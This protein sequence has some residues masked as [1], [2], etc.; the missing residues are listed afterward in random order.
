[1]DED[2]N[3]TGGAQTGAQG[4]TANSNGQ[5]QENGTAEPK[6]YTAEELQAETDRRVTAALKTASEKSQAEFAKQLK[7]AREQWEKESKMSAAEREKAAQE[8]AQAQFEEERAA[9]KKEK[10][11]FEAA[12]LLSEHKIPIGFAKVVTA[13]GGESVE[14]SVKAFSEMMSEYRESVVTEITKGKTPKTGGG[15]TAQ[16]DPFLKGFG[17]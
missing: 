15:Q 7:A 3:V 2:L 10:E 17:M 1:M 12:K 5:G 13:M 6:T 8:A 11:E 14:D 4:A 9:Y 16:T